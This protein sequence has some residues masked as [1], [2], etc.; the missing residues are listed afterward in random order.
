MI[1]SELLKSLFNNLP[2]GLAFFNKDK[3]C[4]CANSFI[5]SLIYSKQRYENISGL[6]DDYINIINN[7]DK[8]QELEFLSN[9]FDNDEKEISNNIRLYT[10]NDAGVYNDADASNDA[11]ALRTYR[12]FSSKKTY[13][14]NDMYLLMLQDIHDNKTLEIQLR[15]ETIK[16]EQ[17][18]DHK[19]IFLANMSHEIRTPLN[20]IIGMLTLLEDTELNDNQQDYLSMIKECS[21]NLM[22]I[23]NDILDFSKLEAGKIILDIKPMNLQECIESTNDII[24][25]KIC[26]KS[27]E[28]IYNIDPIINYIKGDTHRI[29]QILL[30]L[31]VNAIKFTDM[32]TVVLNVDHISEN[33]YNRLMEIYSTDDNNKDKG[34]IKQNMLFLRFNIEDTGCGIDIND[35]D[36]LFKSFSQIDNKISYKIYQGTGLGLAISKE[37][38]ELM[39]GCIWLDWSEL[40]KGSRFSFILKV[41]SYE[42]TDKTSEG[43]DDFVLR[44]KNVLIVDDNLY[45]RISLTGMIKKWGMRPYAFSNSEEALYFTKI[46]QFDIGLIDYC[47]PKIDGPTFALKLREQK[48]FNNKKMPLIAL[49]SLGE[50]ISKTSKYF[51]SY[52]VKPF[53]ESQLKNTCIQLLENNTFTPQNNNNHNNSNNNHY[54]NDKSN[55]HIDNYIR[56]N[57][58][59]QLKNDIRILLAEDVYINQKVIVSYLNKM[60]FNNIQIVENG[61][62]CLDLIKIQ[63]FDIVLL[64]IRMPVMNGEKTLVAIKEFYKNQKKQKYKKIP[65]IIAITA[66]CLSEDRQRYINMG[67]DDYIP[68]PVSYV[69]LNKC[70]NTFIKILL[71]D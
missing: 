58:L 14:K 63:D 39:S 46:T 40:G 6:Y 25:S 15:Q 13:F 2:I 21:F 1:D 51:K 42:D 12:W 54:V 33:E 7:E 28:Y 55:S 30:N 5:K 10:Y 37:L 49:S 3:K 17:A 31:L 52:L 24:V 29:K 16:A 60:G 27:L 26:E 41:E 36:K 43:S 57:N 32:G 47:M 19:S 20:G 59:D 11:G 18:C 71:R 53:K 48:E 67:F 38:I 22:T 34:K 61:Q 35:K 9:F 44:D 62:Q 45:N 66:Y 64:D 8:Q 68:K 65:Y 69:D 56:Q 4:L 50:K 23:I 70:I